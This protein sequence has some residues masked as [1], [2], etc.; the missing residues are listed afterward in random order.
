MNRAEYTNSSVRKRKKDFTTKILFPTM[1]TI[2]LFLLTIFLI[3]IPH[4]KAK[5]MDEKRL[6]IKELTNSAWSVLEEF[7]S[8][9]REGRLSKTEAQ[10]QAMERIRHLRYG[11]DNK[12]YFWISD[13]H[14]NM[15]MHPYRIDL[16]GNNL[17]QFV[18]SHGKQLFL[19]FTK[20]VKDHGHGYVDYMWQ[21]KDDSK[22]IVPK[23]S[24]VKGFKPWGW[25]VGTGI[26]VEDVKK[27][28]RSLTNNLILISLAISLIMVLLLSLI[29][30]Q[31]IK[32]EEARVE[33]ENNLL[34][35]IEKYKT[36]V[37][38]STEG[39][40]MIVDGRITFSNPKVYE[41]T[42]FTNEEL[43][44]QAFTMLLDEE[45]PPETVRFFDQ[46]LLTERQFELLVR[47]KDHTIRELVATVSS[48]SISEKDGN[49]LILKD[50]TPKDKNSLKAD[51]YRQLI[52]SYNLGFISLVLDGKGRILETNEV[53]AKVLGYRD[54]EE[55]S[56]IYFLSLFA[57]QEKGKRFR[58]ELID[59]G[60]VQDNNLQ[61]RRKDGAQIVVSIALMVVGSETN[62][63]ICEGIIEDITQ[64]VQYKNETDTL[65]AEMKTAAL[66]MEQPVFNCMKKMAVI[67]M[68]ESIGTAE[69]I[70]SAQKTD[71]L[72]VITDTNEQI[73]IVTFADIRKRAVYRVLAHETPIF[74][75][76]SAPVV[77]VDVSSS[78]ND[79]M[80][81][82]ADTHIDH[83][84]VKDAHNA[85]AGVVHTK[86]IPQVFYQSQSCI[87]RQIQTATTVD[88]LKNLFRGVITI[89]RPLIEQNMHPRTVGR[90]IGSISGSLTRR[91]IELAIEEIGPPPT[92]FVF[93]ALGSDGRLEQTL[94]TDQDNAI[95]Y[96]DVADD[97]VARVKAYF[98][99]LSQ[100][101]C[102]GL[103]EAGFSFCKGNFMA[104]NPRWCAPLQTWK[105][106]FAGWINTPEPQ[107]ILD[108][109]IFFDFR[110]VYGAFELAE[111]LQ[112]HIN[113]IVKD[114]P[115][116][117][118]HFAENVLSFK[119][120]VKIT[121]SIMTEKVE[122]KELFD[123]KYAVT[124]IV[125]FARIY[126]VFKNIA[127]T[128]TVE[129]LS[130]L[131]KEN[132]I[133][134]QDFREI[135][136]GYTYLMQLRYKH[137]IQMANKN[138]AP[139]NLVEIKELSDSETAL[140]K[141]IFTAVTRLQS[142]LNT[143]FKK[144]T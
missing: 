21:W 75:I 82:T 91:I 50:V 63:L 144:M 35:S 39:L 109:S 74:E 2:L 61:L 111:D 48:I 76:M 53:T 139:D 98:G 123:L 9:E 131:N 23:L 8:F 137:Q 70:M 4:F 45:N 72:S 83:V 60:I 134:D 135:L 69:K 14:P 37:Q 93:L 88:E 33:A 41:L 141:K 51:D 132:V 119:S 80:L 18:D 71:V 67:G 110:P 115:L 54:T 102:S 81:I 32:I 64:Q 108:I 140:I 120:A 113:Q 128:N 30:Q 28:I 126:S 84:V 78:I 117:F 133:S 7:E 86:D 5:I 143:Q 107:N 89:T 58:N 97:E 19:E 85:V 103:N 56:G 77:S 24:Y 122:N 1:I 90:M 22:Q 116:F 99:K 13:M 105:N 87:E 73:G 62:Q 57:S 95:I 101:V 47:T 49:I 52:S 114:K 104:R 42:G 127:S 40:I 94:E 15:V 43:S 130:M 124:P 59:S 29:M 46:S 36:L 27:N 38:A 25:I 16:Q 26:Y 118:Y 34:D 12:D 11:E 6:L 66:F 100:T 92:D 44:G 17:D 138:L 31:S 125:M 68:K 129:R 20:V 142:M 106:N 136:F 96:R 79:I 112:G 10:K 55:L 3:I 121:G 65:I